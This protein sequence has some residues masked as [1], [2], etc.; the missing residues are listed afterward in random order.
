MFETLDLSAPITRELCQRLG[1]NVGDPV[2]PHMLWA[3][4]WEKKPPVKDEYP[5]LQIVGDVNVPFMMFIGGYKANYIK[6][7]GELLAILQLLGFLQPVSGELSGCV[8][9]T[10][11]IVASKAE[12]NPQHTEPQT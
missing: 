8:R 9:A 6:T 5:D 1:A 10:V 7:V 2:R 11:E 4:D 12:A 3:A